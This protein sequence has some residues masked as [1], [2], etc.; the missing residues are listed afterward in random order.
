MSRALDL[1][2]E[3]HLD[4]CGREEEKPLKRRVKGF[5]EEVTFEPK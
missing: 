1:G 5:L 4:N 2:A 3:V